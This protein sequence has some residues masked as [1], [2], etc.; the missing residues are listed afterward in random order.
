M[1]KALLLINPVAK[2]ALLNNLLV[3]DRLTPA[4]LA[5]FLFKLINKFNVISNTV[6]GPKYRLE[7]KESYVG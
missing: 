5:G 7:R 1:R 3:V 4:N 6:T 2:L